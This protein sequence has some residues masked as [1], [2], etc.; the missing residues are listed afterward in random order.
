MAQE[1]FIHDSSSSSCSQGHQPSLILRTIEG[2][3]ICL[4]CLS[5]LISTSKSPTVHVSYA[6]SQFSQAFSQPTFR[7]DLL[8]LHPHFLVLPLVESLS[9]FEDEPIARQVFDIISDL[10]SS[11]DT[12]SV[13]AD[14]LLRISDKLSS[15]ALGWSRRQVHTLHCLGMLLNDKKNNSQANVAD[16]DV[17]LFNLVE[18]LQLPSE[19]IRGE[20]FFILYKMAI[21]EYA[22]KEGSGVADNLS[23]FCPKLLQLSLEALMKIQ[24]DDARLNCIALLTVLA[25]RDLFVTSCADETG[26][27]DF[28]EADN[29]LHGT[30]DVISGSSL[31]VLFAEAMKGTLL[32]SDTEVQVS[33]LNLI[34]LYLSRE[35]GSSNKVQILLDESIADYVFEIL[36]LSGCKD[37][38]VTSSVQVLGLMSTSEQSFRQ[39][40]AIGFSTL[41]PVLQYVAEVPFHAAQS[42][43]L[44][45]LWNCASNCPGIVSVSHVEELST[46][47][48]GMLKKY[49]DGKIDM[50]PETFSMA[51]LILIALMNVPSSYG[52]STFL[53]LVSHAIRHAILN[54]LSLHQQY[55]GNLIHSLHLLREAYSYSLEEKVLSSN[56]L[57][58]TNDIVF[59]CKTQVFPWFVKAVGEIEK[60]EVVLSVLEI[61]QLVMLQDSNTQTREFTEFLVSSSWFSLIF[62]YL[63]SFPTENLK[64]RAYQTFSSVVDVLLG[65]NMGQPIRDAASY[66]PSDPVD[67]LFL[68]GKSSSHSS[69]LVLCH[70]SVFLMLHISSLY[71]DRLADHKLVLTCLEQYMLANSN[72]L[73]SGAAD[74][75]PLE[76]LLSTYGLYRG[77]AK[78]N[79]QIPYSQEAERILFILL[80]EKEWDLPST[81]I[82]P[83]AL[84]WLFQQ[85]RLC[86]PL[87][88]QLLKLCSCNGS[89]HDHTIVNRDSGHYIN[90][91]TLSQLVASGDSY[92]AKLLVCMMYDLIREDV[93]QEKIV[94]VLN[95]VAE[96]IVISPS[97]PVQLC[98]HGIGVVIHNVFSHLGNSYST[99]M[100]LAIC[101]V[102]VSILGS[103]HS[104][105]LLDDEVWATVAVQ[106]M[107]YLA[108]THEETCTEEA[109][110]VFGILSLILH[111]SSNQVLLEAS[112]VIFLSPV[113]V[114][115]INNTISAA[116]GKGPSLV[117]DGEGTRTEQALILV[118]LI[119]FFTLRSVHAVLP[120]AMDWRHFP[121]QTIGKHSL[122][123]VS[124]S[125]CDLCRLMHFGSD[126]VK[127]VSS[128]CLLEMVLIISDQKNEKLDETS[129]RMG[130]ISSVL[131][132]LE[133]LI[134]STDI[135]VA[136]NSSLCLSM[137]LG[138]ED[139]PRRN[140]C[141][142]IVEELVISLA[143]PCSVTK[144]FMNHHKPAVHVTVSLLKQTKTPEWLN[145]ILDDSCISSI[146][147]NIR[148]GNLSTELVLLFI[149]L[150]NAGRLK[151]E[152]IACINKVFQACKKDLYS[153]EVECEMAPSVPRGEK[154]IGFLINT[155]SSQSSRDLYLRKIL[156]GND[157]LLEAIELFSRS[158]ME[159][160]YG[161]I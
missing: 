6:L 68:L 20:I 88:Q 134:F 73:L 135:R 75:M 115:I 38:L 29:F 138:W 104:E 126:I 52:S 110:N 161:I 119:Y 136:M 59:V 4:V 11:T 70:S 62:G 150:L 128:F 55:P 89:T 61:F 140:W 142:L 41:I 27:K 79:Y 156:V 91:G 71:D 23:F 112:K 85:E 44:K 9:S 111:H 50:L 146:I 3:S 34:C 14:F 57:E 74:V 141:R 86:I 129:G 43:T 94:S 132:V 147:K 69:E 84:K 80:T 87:L 159:E 125:G 95:S 12:C 152:D 133:G 76:L 47:L 28:C 137:I 121:S 60:E 78:M 118:L 13:Y 82:H 131:S 97:T 2:G 130:D 145:S 22:G 49:V 26:G 158:L 32:S 10:C 107:E 72:E 64:W 67:F 53:K 42:Q 83:T 37:H 127:V 24:S 144:S 51:C 35:G 117:E 81:R 105:S 90:I 154:I 33:T 120:G 65:D 93:E 56:G 109:L 19:E 151:T 155:M 102:T 114:S 77:L 18:G 8:Q 16:K 100:F 101:E 58:L 139:D 66:L 108:M 153:T 149:E 148:V 124:I 99:E 46:L 116:C 36:R 40:L 39:R 31:D 106:L 96:M 160:D 103:V 25:Q 54:C 7:Q 123:L 45:L 30:E 1:T 17:L 48:V 92:A 143:V 63:G 15:G 21:I 122:E 98:S 5:N 113:L 157:R